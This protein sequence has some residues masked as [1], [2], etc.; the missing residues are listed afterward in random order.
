M[1]AS[2]KVSFTVRDL[3]ASVHAALK[4]EAERDE[5]SLNYVVVRA[6]TAHTKTEAAVLAET[7][8]HLQKNRTIET[9]VAKRKVDRR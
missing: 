5:R 9:P 3:P 6:L 2:D 8:R 1:K 7:L 4:R